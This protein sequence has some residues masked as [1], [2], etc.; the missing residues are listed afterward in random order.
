[1]ILVRRSSLLASRSAAARVS[2]V[3][4]PLTC[5]TRAKV[6][7]KSDRSFKFKSILELHVGSES[8][9]HGTPRA[10]AYICVVLYYRLQHDHG[11]DIEENIK[12]Q[13]VLG[14]PGS[15]PVRPEVRA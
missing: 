11:R 15:R 8:D 5:N 7:T 4:W 14:I 10:S 13:A 1:M 2:S 6:R 3:D 9:N 12:L